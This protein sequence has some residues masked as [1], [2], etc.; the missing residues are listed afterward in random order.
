M[1]SP[2]RAPATHPVHAQKSKVLA[3]ALY[4]SCLADRSRPSHKHSL[5]PRLRNCVLIAQN[6]IRDSSTE[7]TQQRRY[8]LKKL[9]ETSAR[10][11]TQ[12]KD[13][14]R[15]WSLDWIP[16]VEDALCVAASFADSALLAA[17]LEIVAAGDPALTVRTT[18]REIHDF[19]ALARNRKDAGFAQPN[20]YEDREQQEEVEE[21]NQRTADQEDAQASGCSCPHY[22]N[23]DLYLQLLLIE[24]HANVQSTDKEMGWRKTGI[25]EY[26][27]GVS[28]GR[29][30]N[31]EP[32]LS[33]VRREPNSSVISN[34]FGEPIMCAVQHS[35]V[36]ALRWMLSSKCVLRTRSSAWRTG[37]AVAY[38]I[39]VGNVDVISLLLETW[40][41]VPRMGLRRNL[42]ARGFIYTAVF[43][44]KA[45][46]VAAVISAVSSLRFPLEALPVKDADFKAEAKDVA[47][48]AA[49]ESQKLALVEW[50]L[51][52]GVNVDL[53][54]NQGKTALGFAI[55]EK[56]LD[57]EILLRGYGAVDG[58]EPMRSPSPTKKTRSWWR[59]RR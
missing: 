44:G 4:N 50:L 55:Q 47:F 13:P 33:K 56:N 2:F 25:G 7:D 9:C 34:V 26:R 30:V 39:Q 41:S 57:I 36:E 12:I 52:L 3:A 15:V 42:K 22:T 53:R 11:L 48:F 14:Y 49:V 6:Y 58:G 45:D 1:P 5:P 59:C 16:T 43:A 18:R 23:S 40:L 17:L 54:I 28:G 38:A 21:E 46:V 8:I 35:N 31:G 51:G 27:A 10:A 20:E 24:Q 29:D 32:V 37:T 19:L